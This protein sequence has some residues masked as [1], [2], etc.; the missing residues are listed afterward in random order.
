[1]KT[2]IQYTI[3]H[4]IFHCTVVKIHVLI[5][6]ADGDPVWANHKIFLENKNNNGKNIIK[7]GNTIN[8]YYFP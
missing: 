2:Y 1:M 7:T 6:T 4:I 8:W 5:V 3:C